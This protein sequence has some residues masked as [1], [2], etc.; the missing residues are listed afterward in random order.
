M[1]AAYVGFWSFF[2]RLRDGGAKEKTPS[3]TGDVGTLLVAAATEAQLP[4]TGYGEGHLT[5]TE[6]GLGELAEA[7]AALCISAST[8]R[9]EGRP[10]S[11]A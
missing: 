1:V 2:K 10:A 5:K 11:V 8:A 4:K 3:P 9:F 7:A 6:D